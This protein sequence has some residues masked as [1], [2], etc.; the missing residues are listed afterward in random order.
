MMDESALA[1]GIYEKL[2]TCISMRDRYMAASLQRPNDNPINKTRDEKQV[3]L[4]SKDLTQQLPSPHDYHFALTDEGIFKVYKNATDPTSLIATTSLIP[5]MSDYYQD[6]EFVTNIISDGPTKTLTFRRLRYLEA[7]FSIHMLLN[8]QKESDEQKSAPHR[9]FYNVRKVD[10]HVHHSA[11]MNC[12]HLLRFIKGKIKNNSTDIVTFRDGKNLTLQQVFESLNLTS[13]D[14][15]IDKLD[16]HAHKD[17]FHRFDRFNLKYNPIGESRL[18]EIFLKTDNLISGRYLAE[19]TKEVFLELE[20]S[21][22]QMAEYRLSIYGRNVKEWDKLASWVVDNDLFSDNVVW[23]IQIPR[24]YEIYKASGSM[25]SFEEVII[26]VFQ[27][28]FEVTKD[29]SSHPKLFLFLQ[30]VVGFDSVDDESKIERRVHKKYPFPKYWESEANPPYS[31]YLYFMYANMAHLNHFRSIRG[32][33]TFVFRPH[34]GEAG[35]PDHLVN[36]FLTSFSINHGILLRKVP[37]LQY[38]YYLTQMGI[39]ISPLSNNAL[40]LTYDRNPF[41]EYFHRGLNTSLST[42]DPLQFHYTREPLIEEY[43]VAAQIW[44]LSAVDMCEI[45][46]NSVMQSGFPLAIKC[47]WLGPDCDKPGV[48]GNNVAQSNVP[49]IRIAFREQMLKEERGIVFGEMPIEDEIVSNIVTIPVSPEECVGDLKILNGMVDFDMPPSI[50][51]GKS[52][53][54]E[55]METKEMKIKRKG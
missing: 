44:K 2:K 4:K 22:Y 35:D 5:S 3:N 36:S 33:N 7:Q 51:N 1:S 8:E 54:G 42:D 31:Y 9:D 24:L 34:S 47:H 49:N 55:E 6:C 29:P 27:P 43:S 39:A 26:N 28:L 10:T 48:R 17:S 21:K 23:I 14:L 18:R 37:A 41:P 15:N 38:L 45:A 40:F 16:M 52:K 20:Q 53:E 30:R 32:F 12:K 25:S 13:Y 46:M 11:C 19:V 50:L